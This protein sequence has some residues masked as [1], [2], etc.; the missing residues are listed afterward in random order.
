MTKRGSMHKLG[1]VILAEVQFTDTFEVKTRPAVV[2]FE[3]YDNIV[4][5]GVTSNKEMKGI[6]LL[7]KEGAIKDSIIKLN[8]IF[9]ISE[10]M[11]KKSLFSLSAEKKKMV[12]FELIKKLQE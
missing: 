12:V 8:Y 7:K 3:E 2:L 5:A 1:E 6:P 10:K 11:V 9:T 4:V